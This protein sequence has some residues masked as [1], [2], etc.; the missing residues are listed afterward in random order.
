MIEHVPPPILKAT[1]R[2]WLRV[3]RD[4]GTVRIHTPNGDVLGHALIDSASGA[5]NLFWAVQ[6][7]I[8][9]YGLPPELV[10]GPERL[11]NQVDH[12][13][14]LTFSV[15][16]STLEEIGFADVEDVSGLDPCHHVETWA[17]GIPGLCLEVRARKAEAASEP[18]APVNQ[19]IIS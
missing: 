13:M 17:P 6:S 12:R 11:T 16:K 18:R 19:R 5:S 4:G 14:V 15:L 10:S 8:F 3:L 1:L 2:E 7:A 9:G